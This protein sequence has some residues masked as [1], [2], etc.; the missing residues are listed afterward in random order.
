MTFAVEVRGRVHQVVVAR[1][2]GTDQ[3]SIDGRRCVSQLVMA[4]SFG[5]LLVDLDPQ[6][7]DARVCRSY[8]V[9]FDLDPTT[10]TLAVSVDGA[11][12]LV[13]MVDRQR[14]RASASVD[15]LA[16]SQALRAP[17]PGRIVRLLVKP[18][19][20]VVTQQ[21]LVVMEAMKMENE[22]H[23]S[24]AGTVSAVHVEAGSTVEAGA[25]LLVVA[26]ASETQA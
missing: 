19:D 9:A 10:G 22:L 15:A 24:M 26:A 4:D 18:G 3:V 2:D 13:R 20:R 5:S 7:S 8:E 17:M 16:S 11:V 14:S 23:A 1:L 12:T 21:P 25:L 6:G